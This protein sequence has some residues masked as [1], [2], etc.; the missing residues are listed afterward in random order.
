MFP[1]YASLAGEALLSALEQDAIIQSISDIHLSPEKEGVRLEWRKHGVLLPLATIAQT[2]YIDLLRRVKFS[3]K[4]KLNV[5]NIPQDGQYVF[6]AG[7]RSINV[8]VATLPSHFG[9]AMT[10]RLLDP[11]KGIRPL[12]DLGFS[13]EICNTLQELM[14]L[15]NGLILV[16]GPTSSGKTTTLY[17]LLSTII[18][19]ER[20]IVTLE[21]PIEYTLAGIVQSAIDPD[22]DYTFANG[23]RSVLRHD[24][25]VILVGEIRDLETAQTAVSAALT[26]HLVL[27]TLHTNSAVEAIPRLLSMGVSPYTLA[28]ALRAVLAQRLVRTLTPACRERRCDPHAQDSYNGQLALPELL[29]VTPAVEKLI[30]SLDDANTIAALAKKEGFITMKEWGEKAVKEGETTAEEVERVSK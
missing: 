9:E 19:K 16:T 14:T 23:L 22:H 2:A 6:S 30:L 11:A 12:T 15:P 25:N 27:S 8:R 26:G 4:L 20:T 5:T 24:P 13:Q 10:L 7:G 21:D 28:P 29:I 18:G 1:S 17:A 3:A